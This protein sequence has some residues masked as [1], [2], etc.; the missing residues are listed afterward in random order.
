MK[1]RSQKLMVKSVPT[2]PKATK[3]KAAQSKILVGK[4]VVTTVEKMETRSKHLDHVQSES[5]KTVNLGD[6]KGSLN[7]SIGKKTVLQTRSKKMILFR[8]SFRR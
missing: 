6:S 3:K 4:N 8:H 7:S 5:K 2:K 1:T